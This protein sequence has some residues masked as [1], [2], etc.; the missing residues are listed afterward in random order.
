MRMPEPTSIDKHLPEALR[1]TN[2]LFGAFVLLGIVVV[3]IRTLPAWGSLAVGMAW[4]LASL[5]G[6]WAVGFLFGIPKILQS[7]PPRASDGDAKTPA[8]PTP[9]GYRQQV[10]T[11]LTE[12]SDWL[13]KIIV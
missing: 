10:N 11:N 4:M 1:R 9:S 2:L 7:E 6:G 12:I 3:A 8:A 13:T 5:A